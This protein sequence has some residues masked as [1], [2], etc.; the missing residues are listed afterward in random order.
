MSK[1]ET[2]DCYNLDPYQNLSDNFIR[3]MKD[4]WSP[5]L[6]NHKTNELKSSLCLFCWRE[7]Q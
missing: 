6:Y 5:S 7:E 4:E 3:N 1:K 2:I